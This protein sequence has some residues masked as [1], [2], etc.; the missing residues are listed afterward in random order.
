[1]TL[2]SFTYF[3]CVFHFDP[4]F[5]ISSSLQKKK[6]NWLAV[7]LSLKRFNYAEQKIED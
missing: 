2:E 1:M 6:K 4:L 3:A 7:N 5:S